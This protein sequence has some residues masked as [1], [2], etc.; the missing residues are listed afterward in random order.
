MKASIP[1]SILALILSAVSLVR[2]HGPTGSVD[3]EQVQKAADDALRAREKKFVD[4]MKPRFQT[5]FAE[6]GDEFDKGWNPGTIE[7][8]IEP[9]TRIINSVSAE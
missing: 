7:E 9:L 1:L 8:L 2:S 3:Q 5:L 4:Q 6:M